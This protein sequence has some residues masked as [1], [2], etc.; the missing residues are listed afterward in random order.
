MA[1]TKTASIFGWRDGLLEQNIEGSVYFWKRWSLELINCES[2][3]IV[4]REQIEWRR[5]VRQM[6]N[7]VNNV[8]DKS[9]IY[10]VFSFS[11]AYL[12]VFSH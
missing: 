7:G 10:L 5:M 4:N 8:F 6:V 1:I 3:Q 12:T 2:S 9:S 11:S